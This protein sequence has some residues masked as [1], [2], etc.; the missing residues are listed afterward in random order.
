MTESERLLLKSVS[1]GRI[2]QTNLLIKSG[3]NLEQMNKDNQT[4]I[5]RVMFVENPKIQISLLRLLLKH[6]VNV[7]AVDSQ[8]RNAFS[9]AC[10]HGCELAVN[11]LI[12]KC[13]INSLAIDGKDK[14][15]FSPLHLA[16]M[17]GNLNV[18]EDLVAHMKNF[19]MQSVFTLRNDKGITPL[20]E[21]FVNGKFDIA[22]HLITEGNV[23]VEEFTNDILHRDNSELH[24]RDKGNSTP[25]EV[26]IEIIKNV[27]TEQDL[28]PSEVLRLLI[29]NE[30]FRTVALKN[31][32]RQIEVKKRGMKLRA[33]TNALTNQNV[34]RRTLTRAK[35]IKC[36]L[37][38]MMNMYEEQH[39][40]NYRPSS[41]NEFVPYSALNNTLRMLAPKEPNRSVRNTLSCLPDIRRMSNRLAEPSFTRMGRS[42]S[43]Q[44]PQM[45]SW[46]SLRKKLKNNFLQEF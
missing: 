15:G 2:L 30:T 28:A 43:V 31:Y 10:Y 33:A 32:K 39:C 38:T 12:S 41:K 37:P 40:V 8:G 17:N 24:W 22:K 42:T 4:A 1:D 35:S 7:S 26:I 29:T 21:A 25:H 20:I 16:V 34:V 46:T 13:D 14:Y 3:A 44:L 5:I 23:S 11:Y 6:K 9:W 18:V 27:S 19:G 45:N 36:M